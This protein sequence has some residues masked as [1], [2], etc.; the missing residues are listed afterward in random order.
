MATSHRRHTRSTPFAT[1]GS[2][3]RQPG[4]PDG[5]PRFPLAPVISGKSGSGAATAH[6]T[7]ASSRR[8]SGQADSEQLAAVASRLLECDREEDGGETEPGQQGEASLSPDSLGSFLSEV[9]R[10]PRLTG[11]EERELARR[12][13]LG[14]TVARKRMITSNLRLVVW[15]AKGY[16]TQGITLADLIQ[17]GATGLILATEKFDRRLGFSFS[18][19]A[20]WWVRSAVQRG[21]ANKA[22][23]I[24]IPGHA[25]E[26]EQKVSRAENELLARTGHPPT[27]KQIAAEAK[28]PLA[29][30]RNVRSAAR[31][32]DSIDA[33][34]GPGG[35]VTLSDLLVAIGP[36]IEDQVSA[37]FRAVAVRRAVAK[38]PL[39]ERNVIALRYGFADHTPSTVTQTSHHLSTPPRRVRKIEADALRR[40]AADPALVAAAA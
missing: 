17:E 39:R 38:L 40:L 27:D 28:L 23:T 2:Q 33:S 5:H 35:N 32:V 29:H 24:R 34:L 26:H 22:L 25:A 9:G 6:R 14:D 4:E 11:A 3:R 16:Q 10:F 21:V 8:H 18:T 19:H 37:T 30:V 13:A 1:A 20:Y 31:A 36:S 12:I 7:R 15:I